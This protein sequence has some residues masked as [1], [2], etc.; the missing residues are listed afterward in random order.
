[1]EPDVMWSALL[2]IIVTA[3]G[4]WVKSWTGE[5]ARLQILLNKTREEYIT[6]SDSLAQMDRVMNRLDG[7]DA[8]IDRILE[9]G[10]RK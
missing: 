3:I 6:K 2:S 9:N 10:S 5:M 7:L 1:M 4:F 8:K